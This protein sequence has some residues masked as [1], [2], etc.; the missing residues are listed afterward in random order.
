M[1]RSYVL[2]ISL[3]L[4]G[5][6]SKD[7]PEIISNDIFVQILLDYENTKFSN[8]DTSIRDVLSRICAKHSISLQS[9][10]E[11]MDMYLENPEEM[12]IILN[13]LKDSIL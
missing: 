3:F 7:Q 6:I 1:V 9:Y 4:F 12:L 8:H 13:E 2:I 5:C 10:D 11:T